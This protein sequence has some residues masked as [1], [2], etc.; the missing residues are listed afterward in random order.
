MITLE[1]IDAMRRQIQRWR[2]ADD[3]IAL[4]PTMGNLHPGHLKLVE[5]AMSTLR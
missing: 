5:V 2:K 1:E 4:V 3:S